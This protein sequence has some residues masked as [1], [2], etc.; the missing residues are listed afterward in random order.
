MGN[1]TMHSKS[2]FTYWWIRETAN[3]KFKWFAICS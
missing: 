1:I 2:H 3:S